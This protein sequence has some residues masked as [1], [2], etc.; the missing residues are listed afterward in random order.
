MTDADIRAYLTE[1]Y[2]MGQRNDAQELEVLL[3]ADN[4]LSHP[5]DLARYLK[6]LE[7]LPRFDR[8]VIPAGKGL[9][10]AYQATRG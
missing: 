3:L 1:L 5:G 7:A 6:E 10:V 9:S 2:E 4:V 8:V